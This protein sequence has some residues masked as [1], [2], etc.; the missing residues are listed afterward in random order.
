[1]QMISKTF[2]PPQYGSPRPETSAGKLATLEDGHPLEGLP[3]G[4][5]AAI[6]EDYA[7]EHG[8][9]VEDIDATDGAKELASE[10]SVDLRQV[11]GTGQ[12]GRIT[13]GDVEDYI[14]EHENQ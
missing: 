7:A 13:K 2:G 3:E 12:D 10:Q 1:M 6:S 5:P 14:A 8:A 4:H 9:F 11:A